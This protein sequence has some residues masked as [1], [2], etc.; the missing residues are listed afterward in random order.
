MSVPVPGTTDRTGIIPVLVFKVFGRLCFK[1][2]ARSAPPRGSLK[3]LKRKLARK[4]AA[5]SMS[6]T[7]PEATASTTGSELSKLNRKQAASSRSTTA[8]ETTTS[9]TNTLLE[10]ELSKLNTSDSFQYREHKEEEGETEMEPEMKF[11][12]KPAIKWTNSAGQKCI[13]IRGES[14]CL[15]GCRKKVHKWDGKAFKCTKPGCKCKSFFFIVAEGAWKLRCSCKHHA[16]P[17]HDPSPGKHKCMRR[18]CNCTG[19]VSPWVCNCGAPWNAHTQSIEMIK[20]VSVGGQE[21][22]ASLFAQMAGVE[23]NAEGIAPEIN[24][25]ARDP[26]FGVERY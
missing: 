21:M 18:N 15:C 17:D 19:F 25:V 13:P 4:Q 12:T 10:S 6:T 26:K 5:S 7:A 2:S 16:A 3:L 8:P 14:R 20:F 23:E 9:N 22:P 1:M 24:R 11:Y